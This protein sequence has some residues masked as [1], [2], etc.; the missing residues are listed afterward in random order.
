MNKGS[1]LS[2]IPIH[3]SPIIVKY[4]WKNAVVATGTHT[5]THTQH[6]GASGTAKL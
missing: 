6:T 4:M 5:H 2:I 1:F 3:L